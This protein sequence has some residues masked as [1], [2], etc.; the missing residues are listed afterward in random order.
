MPPVANDITYLIKEDLPP[1][2]P[3]DRES[4]SY[5][6]AHR[7]D[8]IITA[9]APCALLKGP[10][11]PSATAFSVFWTGH[12]VPCLAA[13]RTYLPLAF[14]IATA[15]YRLSPPESALPLTDLIMRPAITLQK[16]CTDLA[17]LRDKIYCAQLKAEAHFEQKH[18]RPIQHYKSILAHPVTA[19]QALSYVA[20]TQHDLPPL[21]KT[22]TKLRAQV[23]EIGNSCAEENDEENITHVDDWGQSSSKV[24]RSRTST[25][26]KTRPRF[27]NFLNNFTL[28]TYIFDLILLIDILLQ[29]FAFARFY[30]LQSRNSP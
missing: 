20:R 15:N 10:D 3:P 21:D 23:Q 4:P 7:C 19:L 1:P 8:Y 30:Y 12:T 5:S 22:L 18:R 28:F 26:D 24:R 16:Q 29:T 27:Q 17:T 11:K 13:T 9:A 14:N 25:A 6:L 2:A